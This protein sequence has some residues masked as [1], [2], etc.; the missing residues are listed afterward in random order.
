M[1][2]FTPHNPLPQEAKVPADQ[3]EYQRRIK[4]FV[5]GLYV[6]RDAVVINVSVKAGNHKLLFMACTERVSI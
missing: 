3:R 6:V 4:P 5:L 2:Q 1:Q